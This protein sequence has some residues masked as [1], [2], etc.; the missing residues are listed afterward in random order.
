MSSRIIWEKPRS[1]PGN[2]EHPGGKGGHGRQVHVLEIIVLSCLG[3]GIGFGVDDTSVGVTT[4]TDCTQKLAGTCSSTLV[5]PITQDPC[6]SK[7]FAK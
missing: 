5:L 6:S 3:P 2:L 4:S 1:Q 7:L